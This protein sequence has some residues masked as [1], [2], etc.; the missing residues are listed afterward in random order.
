MQEPSYI[1]KITLVSIW[2]RMVLALII[3]WIYKDSL[4]LTYHQISIFDWY[5]KFLN[6]WVG[7]LI[8]LLMLIIDT[9]HSPIYWSNSG[10]NP[11]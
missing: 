7:S 10:I 3:T 8:P 4:T 2:F 5:Y 1:G 11:F 6:P 9:M